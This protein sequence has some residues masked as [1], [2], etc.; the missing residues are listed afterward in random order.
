M[1]IESAGQVT[2]DPENTLNSPRVEMNMLSAPR[3]LTVLRDGVHLVSRI[4]ACRPFSELALDGEIPDVVR[5]M[6]EGGPVTDT[7]LRGRTGD[8]FHASGT[9]RMGGEGDAEAVV[10]THGRVLGVQGLHVIDASVFPQIPSANT[11]WPVVVA[12]ERLTAALMGRCFE[13]VPAWPVADG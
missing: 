2:L 5:K 10:D 3:D 11:Y 6:Q 4:L 12:A 9:C 8:Y 13:E 7:W 1:T